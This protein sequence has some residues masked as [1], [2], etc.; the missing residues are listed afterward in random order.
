MH[1]SMVRLGASLMG[2]IDSRKYL[3]SHPLQ[4]LDLLNEPL[5]F[6]RIPLSIFLI[7]IILELL[8]RSNDSCSISS[9]KLHKGI[10]TL[11]FI[12]YGFI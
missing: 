3:Q 11:L 9:L 10:K 1:R 6:E 5:I 8:L 4:N 2:D 7:F 12:D